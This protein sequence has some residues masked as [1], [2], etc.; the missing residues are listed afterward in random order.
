MALDSQVAPLFAQQGIHKLLSLSESC[1]APV[2][3]R[4]MHC[5]LCTRPAGLTPPHPV[6]F[7]TGGAAIHAED[8]QVSL[9]IFG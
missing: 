1:I 2:K 5:T 7:A 3:L 6:F 4:R 9:C 8:A